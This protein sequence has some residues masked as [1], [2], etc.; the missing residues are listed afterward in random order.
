MTV[1]E[2]IE[3]LQKMPPD[4]DVFV[5]TDYYGDGSEDSGTTV[6]CAKEVNR[7]GADEVIVVG[8]D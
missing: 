5:Q 7:R 1:K 4:A 3:A 6:R 8:G 2:L